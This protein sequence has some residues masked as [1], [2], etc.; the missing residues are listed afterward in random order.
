MDREDSWSLVRALL[1]S[2]E[3]LT[4]MRNAR[5]LQRGLRAARPSDGVASAQ[6]ALDRRLSSKRCSSKLLSESL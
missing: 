1:D 2:E 3:P 5:P 6:P 4:F